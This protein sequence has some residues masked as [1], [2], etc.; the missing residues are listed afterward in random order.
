MPEAAWAILDS[1]DGPAIVSLLEVT[2]ADV[3]VRLV[4]LRTDGEPLDDVAHELE[5]LAEVPALEK[6][7]ADLQRRLGPLLFVVV[8]FG[9]RRL[10]MRAGAIEGPFLGE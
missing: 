8:I 5:T 9:S 7:D 6:A 2:E 10:E 3:V 1:G 4:H